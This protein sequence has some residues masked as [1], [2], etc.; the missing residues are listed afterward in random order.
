MCYL[1]HKE[2]EIDRFLEHLFMSN[3]VALNKW[4]YKKKKKKKKTCI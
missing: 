2:D 4:K 1:K 3:S